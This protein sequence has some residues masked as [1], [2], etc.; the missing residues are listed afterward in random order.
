MVIDG[1]KQEEAYAALQ[2][3]RN[4]DLAITDGSVWQCHGVCLVPYDANLDP[5][6]TKT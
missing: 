2:P 6:P 1:G 5:V 4:K 3:C